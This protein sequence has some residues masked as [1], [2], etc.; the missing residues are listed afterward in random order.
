LCRVLVERP[1]VP[2]LALILL[3]AQILGVQ[4]TAWSVH[5]MFDHQGVE[6]WILLLVWELSGNDSVVLLWNDEL[7]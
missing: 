2:A 4:S 7:I 1:W 3:H 6:F 5:H